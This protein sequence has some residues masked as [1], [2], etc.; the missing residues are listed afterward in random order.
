MRPLI[1]L[2]L[3]VPLIGCGPISREQAERDCL[4]RARL[5]EGPRGEIF[6]G[7]ASDGSS[8]VGGEISISSDFISGA[9]PSQVYEQCVTQKSGE[10]PSRPYVSTRKP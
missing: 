9:D 2:L 3:L 5:A 8:T 1:A 6:A 7:I 10:L 4:P